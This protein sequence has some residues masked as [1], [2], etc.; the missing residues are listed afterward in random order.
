[1]IT[2]AAPW[3]KGRAMRGVAASLPPRYIWDM[4]TLSSRRH[5]LAGAAAAL[6]APRAAAAQAPADREHQ[7]TFDVPVIAEDSAG[8][9]MN[10]SVEHPM[11]A[12]HYIRS[13]EITLDN[14]PVPRKGTYL[15]TPLSGRAWVAFPMRSGTG[16]VMRAVIECTRHGRFVATRELRVAEGGCA[17]GPEAID[18]SRLGNPRLALPR[19]IRPGAVIEVKAQLDHPSHTG[20]GLQG[21]KFVREAPEFYVRALKIYLDDQKVSEFEL[22]SA[23]SANP[24][25][26]FAFRAS[27]SG[28]LRVVFE[29]SEGQRWEA[30]QPIRV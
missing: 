12:D 11:E 27:K 2:R 28:M 10:V 6:L 15:F 14:D 8:V 29:N 18:R 4:L 1:M 16:G 3:R 17:T 13:L 19:S 25:F 26:R 22:T 21:G 9:P 24:L 7:I 5:F 23:I 30:T 20:L